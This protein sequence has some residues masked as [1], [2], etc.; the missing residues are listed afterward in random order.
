MVNPFKTPIL[1]NVFN[2]PDCT[3]RV[4]DVIKLVKPKYLYVHCDGARERNNGDIE[5]VNEVRKI[6]LDGVDWDCELKIL[7]RDENLGCGLGPSSAITWFFENVDEGIILEDDCLP[8]PDFFNYCTELLNKTGTI[9]RF[10]LLG[11]LT[12]KLI[13]KY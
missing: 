9:S 11:A 12:L 6:I 7:F 13:T 3:K 10:I 8:H 1:F 4:F 2:R 5:K